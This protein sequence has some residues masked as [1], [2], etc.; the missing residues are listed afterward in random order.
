MDPAKYSTWYAALQAVPD[1]RHKRGQRYPWSLLLTLIAAALLSDQTHLSAIGHWA[2]LHAEEIMALLKLP[3]TRIPSASTLYRAAQAVDVAALQQCLNALALPWGPEATS[4]TR[5]R[6]LTGENLQAQAVDGKVVRGASTHGQQVRL[7]SLVAHGT[8]MT[9]SQTRVAPQRGEQT[10]TPPLLAQRPLQGTVSTFDAGLAQRALA[11]QIVDQRGHY[12]MV[13]KRNE[14]ELYDNLRLWFDPP[15]TLAWQPCDGEVAVRRSQTTGKAHGR[16][17]VRT[18][19]SRADCAPFLDWPGVGQ[20]MRRT[21]WRRVL[22]SGQSSRET[23]YAITSLGWHEA[24]ASH[25]EQLWRGHWTIENRC[26]YVRDVT[27]DEDRG[28]SHVGHTPE[29]L[30]TFRNALIATLRAQGWTNIA[31]ALRYYGSAVAN[32]FALLGAIPPRL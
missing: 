16:V 17:E 18:L 5:L 21:C 15:P 2:S 27:L 3:L 4:E 32:A 9:L 30:A 8:G 28:Q 12:L 11:Q 13:V 19:E 14:P 31:A 26:H 6:L 20:V 1:P 29:V 10:A 7:V 24:D 25:L 22:K 23:T